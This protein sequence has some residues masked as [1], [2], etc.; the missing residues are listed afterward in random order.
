ML[1]KFFFMKMPKFKK[2]QEFQ[3]PAARNAREARQLRAQ[4]RAQKHNT[5]A[6]PVDVIMADASEE[7]NMVTCNNHRSSN[8]LHW[9]IGNL[10]YIF[11]QVDPGI[12]ELI[13]VVCV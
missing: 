2:A 10:D 7:K 1:N 4:N 8:I 5:K 6:K 3:Q 9:R 13:L 11:R 12:L